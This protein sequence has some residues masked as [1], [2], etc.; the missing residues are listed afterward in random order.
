[1]KLSCNANNV[2]VQL[3]R[4]HKVIATDYQRGWE[5]DGTNGKFQLAICYGRNNE[6]RMTAN[7]NVQF[8]SEYRLKELNVSPRASLF[9][10][11]RSEFQSYDSHGNEK[12]T[13]VF[14]VLFLPSIL[15]TH[16]RSLSNGYRTAKRSCIP[17]TPSHSLCVCV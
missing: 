15:N 2:D 10:V 16:T 1:M 3:K 14:I 11:N 12:K 4:V 7:K 8:R 9:P 6:R 5:R 17:R 13:A